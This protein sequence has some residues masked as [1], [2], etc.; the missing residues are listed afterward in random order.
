LILKV[1]RRILQNLVEGGEKGVARC[2]MLEEEYSRS[3]WKDDPTW[4]ALGLRFVPMSFGVFYNILVF[5][6]R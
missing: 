1:G 5:I 3:S 6:S 2:S 4:Q